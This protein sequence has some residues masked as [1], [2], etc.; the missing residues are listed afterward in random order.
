M[1]DDGTDSTIIVGA[2]VAMIAL[3]GFFGGWRL[4]LP[5]HWEFA[6]RQPAFD[7]LDYHGHAHL[8]LAVGSSHLSGRLSTGHRAAHRTKPPRL[9]CWWVEPFWLLSAAVGFAWNPRLWVVCTI[10][11]LALFVFFFTTVFTYGQ[12]VFTGMVNSLGYWLEQQGVRR[13]S[14]PQYYYTLVQV[15][16]YEFMPLI[17]ASIAGIAGLSH[18]FG[19][20]AQSLALEAEGSGDLDNTGHLD[21]QRVMAEQPA[22]ADVIGESSVA[23]ED[24]ETEPDP[25]PLDGLEYAGFV[26]TPKAAWARPYDHDEELERRETQH[27]WLGN[28]PFLAFGRILGHVD[29]RRTQHGG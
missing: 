20:R 17:L 8:A 6:S 12:G 16:I 13:G 10:V 26:A 22:L 19:W 2:V 15:P 7:V 5:E 3:A 28:L 25:P 21:M 1:Q 4:I 18:L 29:V 9:C 11:F 14:Q 27:E 23:A 24:A